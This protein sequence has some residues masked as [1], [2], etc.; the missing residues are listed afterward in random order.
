M[1]HANVITRVDPTSSI[2]SGGANENDGERGKERCNVIFRRDLK[3]RNRFYVALYMV[4]LELFPRSDADY[5]ASG[6]H[7]ALANF[8]ACGRIFVCVP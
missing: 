3:Q 6:L 5:S 7:P 2:N 8:E 4:Q 1:V